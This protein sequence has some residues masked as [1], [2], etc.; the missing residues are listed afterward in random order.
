[1]ATSPIHHRDMFPFEQLPPELRNAIYDLCFNA[2][3][4]VT[5]RRRRPQPEARFQIKAAR[6]STDPRK[7]TGDPF[8]L[9]GGT[10]LLR[11]NKACHA[12][13]MPVLYSTNKLIFATMPTFKQFIRESGRGI[14]FL[15]RIGVTDWEGTTLAKALRRFNGATRLVEFEVSVSA[16]SCRKSDFD[17][18]YLRRA[19]DPYLNNRKDGAS[20]RSRLDFVTFKVKN[21]GGSKHRGCPELTLDEAVERGRKAK[22]A[23]ETTFLRAAVEKR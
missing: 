1:M 13:A 20:A 14:P 11:L 17:G 22:T 10:A 6:Q 15:T 9:K 23:L 5:L 3:G 4:P 16:C 2:G 7:I 21:R 12:E 18:S 8:L 19:L